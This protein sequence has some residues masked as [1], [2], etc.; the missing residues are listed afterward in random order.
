MMA[1]GERVYYRWRSSDDWNERAMLCRVY[2][3]MAKASSRERRLKSSGAAEPYQPAVRQ[4]T[5]T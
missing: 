5:G 4:G 3:A 1:A 2:R